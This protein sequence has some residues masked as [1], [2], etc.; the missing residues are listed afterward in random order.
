MKI[1]INGWMASHSL[2]G[3][4]ILLLS[5]MKNQ[6]IHQ[7]ISVVS[8]VENNMSG[9]ISIAN[10]ASISSNFISWLVKFQIKVKV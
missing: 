5:K 9:S 3:G 8:E 10:K 1:N 6:R 7:D 2:L 4:N